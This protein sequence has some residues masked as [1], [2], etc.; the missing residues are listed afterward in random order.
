MDAREQQQAGLVL[1]EALRSVG[2]ELVVERVRV[3]DTT[4]PRHA[5]ELLD[6]AGYETAVGYLYARGY[7]LRLALA[8]AE[9]GND[10]G[11]DSDH[12]GTTPALRLLT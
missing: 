3:R 8:K 6:D 11:R 12:T 7:R 4:H 2:F 1:R 5:E 10:L 9:V